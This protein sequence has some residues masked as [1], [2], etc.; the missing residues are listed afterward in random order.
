MHTYK[1]ASH[2]LHTRMHAYIH[3][4]IYTYKH[5]IHTSHYITL[6]H[7]TLHHITSIHTYMYTYM[8]HT[9]IFAYT[10]IHTYIH[11][12]MHKLHYITFDFV[13][14][15]LHVITLH[16]IHTHVH[17]MH[18]IHACIDCIHALHTNIHPLH[19][20]THTCTTLNHIT[21]RYI[22]KHKHCIYT[23][24]HCIHCMH[25]CMHSCMHACIHTSHACNASHKHR[26]ILH[27]DTI[28]V[29]NAIRTLHA[30]H[31][32]AIASR[33]I[34]SQ[35]NTSHYITCVHITRIHTDLHTC[36][37]WRTFLHAYVLALHACIH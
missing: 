5:A 36:I 21:S 37:T 12:Y 27:H 34:T 18:Y 14:I 11:T 28:H 7:I 22:K 6:H 24:I 9:Y 23:C 13:F 16:Y 31:R 19:E 25:A 33:Y 29:A 3:S 30:S 17:C 8:L 2:T 10:Y 1:H 32:I 4:L 26:M 15:I 20:Y 35:R